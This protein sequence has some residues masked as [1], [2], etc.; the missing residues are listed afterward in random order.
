L[1]YEH[2]PFCCRKF[3]EHGPLFKECPLNIQASKASDTKQK[4]GF[5]TV[6]GRKKNTPRKQNLDPHPNI[7]KKNL[8]KI[9]NQLPE[10]REIEDPHKVKQ[11]EKVNNQATPSSIQNSKAN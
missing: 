11:Y 5:T 3:H 9:L 7:L 6:T 2:I 8:Y 4:D 1:D 10:D